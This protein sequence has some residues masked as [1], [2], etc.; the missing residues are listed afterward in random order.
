VRRKISEQEKER[1]GWT[2]AWGKEKCSRNG[3]SLKMATFTEELGR[4]KGRLDCQVRGGRATLHGAR[5]RSLADN[6][7]PPWGGSEK[8]PKRGRREQAA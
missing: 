3:T 5:G 8:C 6:F 1:T 2:F 7:I 4:K